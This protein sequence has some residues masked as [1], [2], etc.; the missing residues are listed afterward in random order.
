MHVVCTFIPYSQLVNY[1]KAPFG[2]HDST[3]YTI[4]WFWK[5]RST[6]QASD[7]IR[8]EYSHL[9]IINY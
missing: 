1:Y 6:M 8:E 3:V 2:W 7:M 4:H 5:D 9:P